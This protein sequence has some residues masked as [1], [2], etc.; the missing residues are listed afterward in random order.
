MKCVHYIKRKLRKHDWVKFR[1]RIALQFFFFENNFADFSNVVRVKKKKN[2]DFVQPLVAFLI[3][4]ISYCTHPSF[5]LVALTRLEVCFM[6]P[7]PSSAI[8]G[9]WASSR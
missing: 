5:E 8:K 4:N 1:G 2:K 7:P 9:N 6:D 3:S